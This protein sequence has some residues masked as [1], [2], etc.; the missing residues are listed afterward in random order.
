[1]RN[2]SNKNHIRIG[3]KNAVALAALLALSISGT[4]FA[5]DSASSSRPSRPSRPTTELRINAESRKDMREERRD[6]A[7]TSKAEA[8]EKARLRVESFRE[9]RAER[10]SEVRAKKDAI[11]AELKVR[12]DDKKQKL[13][14]DAK[15]RIENRMTNVYERLTRHV[16]SITKADARISIRVNEVV[17]SGT[18]AADLQNL[19]A[20]AQ[21]ALAKAKVDIEATKG[22]ALE[23]LNASSTSKE[24][25]KSVV[26]TAEASIK[27][28]AQAYKEVLL[29]LKPYAPKRNATSTASASA[30]AN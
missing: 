11:L 1:M 22:I 29:A 21:I 28:A 5:Q 7:S 26:K 30:T 15:V 14:A 8:I 17:A 25:L 2:T 10:M 23:Q 27:A 24:A 12:K 18:I 16:E 3:A 6:I 9:N 20:A 4:A 19:H 13:A